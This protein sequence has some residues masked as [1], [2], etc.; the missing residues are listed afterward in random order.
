MLDDKF[1]LVLEQNV[2]G[3][4][5]PIIAGGAIQITPPINKDYWLLRVHVGYG[6]NVVL[7]PKFGTFG[8]GFAKEENWNTNLPRSCDAEKIYSHIEYNKGDV[9]IPK[10]RCIRAIQMLQQAIQKLEV[11]S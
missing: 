2:A 3:T 11:G 5:E 4:S 1:E 6:Q 8:I 7:F 10:M 9:R